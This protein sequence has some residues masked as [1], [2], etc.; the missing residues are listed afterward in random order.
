MKRIIGLCLLIV[1]LCCA[2]TPLG[3]LFRRERIP[4]VKSSNRALTF[5]MPDPPDGY[6]SVNSAN[7]EELMMLPGVGETLAQAILEEK[8]RHGPFYY[9]EDLISVK[10]IGQSKLRQMRPY[11]DMNEGE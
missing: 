10:G 2:L 7:A 5:Q 6:V 9:A 1:S 8:K 4:A 3:N 11:L